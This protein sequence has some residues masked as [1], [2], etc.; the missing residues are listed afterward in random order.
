[1]AK[2][3][4]LGFLLSENVPSSPSKALVQSS[5][6]LSCAFWLH[7]RHSRVLPPRA[8]EL[9]TLWYLNRAGTGGDIGRQGAGF[10][11]CLC[12]ARS[13]RSRALLA[14]GS[15]H[16]LPRQPGED[17]PALWVFTLCFLVEASALLAMNRIEVWAAGGGSQAVKW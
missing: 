8:C 11:S 5:P 6:S 3:N 16:H 15:L 13:G 4:P 2:P 1:M 10:S 7:F 12:A 9:L 14:S 17:N